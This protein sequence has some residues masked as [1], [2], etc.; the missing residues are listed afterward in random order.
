MMDISDIVKHY[1][2]LLIVLAG[3]GDLGLALLYQD[4]AGPGILGPP[5]H[6]TAGLRPDRA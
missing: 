1:L 2:L 3:G 5:A 6:Q 4:Q